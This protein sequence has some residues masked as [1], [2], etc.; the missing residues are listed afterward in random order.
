MICDNYLSVS[1]GFMKQFCL[2]DLVQSYRWRYRG[3]YNVKICHSVRGPNFVTLHFDALFFNFSEG[4]RAWNLVIWETNPHQVTFSRDGSS[5][6]A[7]FK[8]E[9]Y[10]YKAPYLGCC[11]SPRSASAF[12]ITPE[13]MQHW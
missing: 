10:Y 12:Y 2:I 4:S 7:T 6:A 13:E 11:S 9:R 3:S 8:M 5:T 1:F